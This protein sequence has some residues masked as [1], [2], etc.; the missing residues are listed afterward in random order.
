MSA[1]RQTYDSMASELYIHSFMQRE[2]SSDDRRTNGNPFGL[3]WMNTHVR[4]S[5]AHE[6]VDSKATI[7][8]FDALDRMRVCCGVI[9]HGQAM[10][11]IRFSFNDSNLHLFHKYEINLSF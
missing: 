7:F 5:R 2:K 11:I 9:Y 8:A 3:V 4:K 10:R 1:D 6:K